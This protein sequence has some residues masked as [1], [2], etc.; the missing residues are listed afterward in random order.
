MSISEILTK[1]TSE[2]ALA[3]IRF[4]AALPPTWEARRIS[5]QPFDAGTSVG[6]NYRATCRARSKREFTSKIGLVIE[7]ADESEYWLMLLKRAGI[8]KGVELD[9]L[10]DEAGQ[11][12]AVFTRSQRTAISKLEKETLARKRKSQC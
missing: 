6:A 7:E 10:F 5:G 12:V 1:R 8:A 3:I 11:L 2:F 9:R 4:C